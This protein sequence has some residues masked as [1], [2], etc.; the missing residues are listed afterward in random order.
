MLDS[1][2]ELALLNKEDIHKK[3]MDIYKVPLNTEKYWIDYSTTNMDP[4]K[5]ISAGDGSINKK[6]YLSFVFYAISA[7]TLTYKKNMK[8]IENSFIDIT[9][10]QRFLDDRIRNYMEIYEYKNALKTIQNY[11]PDYFLFD[12][13]VMGSLIRPLPLEKEL[14]TNIKKEIIEDYKIPLIKEIKKGQVTISSLQFKNELEKYGDIKTVLMFLE[15]IETLLVIKEIL[16][17]KDKI[18][19]IS[20]TSSNK[21]Y[22]NLDMPDMSIFDLK[23]DNEGYSKPY[24]PKVSEKQFK[25]E[26]NI[27]NEYFKNQEFSIFYTRLEKNKNILKFEVPY[28]LTNSKIEELINIIKPICTEG[29][30]YLLKKAHHDVVI[31][32]TD[33]EQLIKIMGFYEKNGREML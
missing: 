10:P 14:P 30:P 19:G 29:Y 26:Y 32:K 33:M 17:Y 12:G 31:K 6:K 23:H 8:K 7:E 4:T 16:E 24:S 21:D 22:F 13:S 18:I 3:L 1:L 9:T 27:E 11:N 28:K 2:L 5:I 20:K 15:S 25:H